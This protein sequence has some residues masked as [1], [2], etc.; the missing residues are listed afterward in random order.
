MKKYRW[1]AIT[2]TVCV[3]VLFAAGCASNLGGSSYSR[4]EARKEQ[5][6]ELGKVLSVR[7][8]TIEGTSGT[9]GVIA[10]GTT[11]AVAGSAVGGGKGKIVGG[12]LGGIGGA[13]A[14]SAIEKGV[15]KRP[16]VELTLAMDNGKTIA[17]VQ[18]KG[19]TFMP[20]D[21]V[22]VVKTSSGTTR[23]TRISQ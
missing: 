6:V 11:G 3:I 18:E 7:D 15:T 14:G 1:I 20:G 17:V 13:I 2:C 21:R 12:V 23:V 5:S 8:V 16:G 9:V 19:E 10:G 22:Q 4:D